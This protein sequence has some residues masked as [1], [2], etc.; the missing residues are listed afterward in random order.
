MIRLHLHGTPEDCRLVSERLATVFTVT[1]VSEPRKDRAPSRLVRVYVEAELPA[2]R[3][4]DAQRQAAKVI[5]DRDGA[6]GRRTRPS[7]RKIAATGGDQ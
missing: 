1:S 2:V 3:V 4:T 7:V 5:T 6:A